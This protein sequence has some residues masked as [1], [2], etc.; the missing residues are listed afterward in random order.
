MKGESYNRAIIETFLKVCKNN[1]HHTVKTWTMA[2]CLQS[3]L[4]CLIICNKQMLAWLQLESTSVAI[5]FVKRWLKPSLKL[6]S[7][8]F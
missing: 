3:Q 7:S 6:S 4:S 8:V 5:H 1:T 2:A